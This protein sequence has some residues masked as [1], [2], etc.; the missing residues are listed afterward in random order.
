M[1]W[2]K[3]LLVVWDACAAAPSSGRKAEA[4]G[5]RGLRSGIVEQTKLVASKLHSSSTRTTHN[6]SCWAVQLAHSLLRAK[7]N[8]IVRTHARVC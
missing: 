1:K 8:A 5:G 7:P 2:Q 3:V 6:R 4:A